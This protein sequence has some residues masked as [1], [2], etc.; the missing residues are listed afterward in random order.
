MTFGPGGRRRFLQ[1]LGSSVMLAAAGGNPLRHAAGAN[2]SDVNLDGVKSDA[3]LRWPKPIGSPVLD[4]LR[5]V[6]ENSR[7]VHTHVEKIVE[8]AGWMAYEELPMPEYHLPTGVG[9]N[10]P[11][12]AIDFIMV[13]DV[14]DTAF[15]DFSTHVKFTTEYA[16]QH[17]SDSE[18]EFACLKRAMDN[19]IPIL[20]GSFL[21]K[22]TRQQLNEIFSGNIEMPMLD[23]KLAV[24]HQVGPVLAEKYKGRFSNFIHS[25]PPRLYDNGKGIIDRLVVEFPRF[26]DV[27]QYDGHEI[28]LYKLPQLGIWFV[29]SSLHPAGKFQLEDIGA[30]TAFADYI[31]PVALRLLGIT[32]YSPALEHAI[33]TYQMIPRD[34]TQEVEIRAHC[35]YAT[36]LLREEVNKI[37]PA[38]KQIIIPQIDARLWMPYHTT[39]WPHHLTKTIMY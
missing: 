3:S 29:Y 39:F 17:W 30:M 24:L 4:S 7:D 11:N 18:A 12:E 25:C 13:A 19:G 2:P 14:I 34:S 23:E 36:A 5:P 8:V 10:D 16:G 9:V 32:S 35:I 37:R 22:I 38:D 26:N 20:D 21:A 28:K 15:T 27:S 31:V 6:I 1:G 33:N